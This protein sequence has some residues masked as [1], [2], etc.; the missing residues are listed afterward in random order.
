MIAEIGIVTLST[1]SEFD[2]VFVTQV[3]TLSFSAA[4]WSNAQSPE[5]P[6]RESQLMFAKTP[7][8]GTSPS[9]L[10][11]DKFNICKTWRFCNSLGITPE[12]LLKER[13]K[14]PSA[15]RFSSDFGIGLVILFLVSEAFRWTLVLGPWK[16][17][18]E[19][20]RLQGFGTSQIL[21]GNYRSTDYHP[22]KILGVW[23]IDLQQNWEVRRIIGWN[24]VR[25]PLAGYS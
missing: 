1:K 13:A 14:L 6:W 17:F 21:E 19:L 10:L 7:F 24:S 15:A 5:F 4:S 20:I 22:Y 8:V 23:L 16:S 12:R 25:Y 9:K 3:V 11:K 18:V 2:F